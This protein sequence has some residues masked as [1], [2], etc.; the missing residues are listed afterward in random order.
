M[1]TQTYADAIATNMFSD[2]DFVNSVNKPVIA[3]VNGYAL[4]GGCEL[5]M[6][7]DL[8]VMLEVICALLSPS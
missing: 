6:M 7:C 3:A 2:W 8:M 5:A 4:G 1:S